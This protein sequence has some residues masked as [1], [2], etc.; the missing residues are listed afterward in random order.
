MVKANF[1]KSLLEQADIPLGA[2]TA[3]SGVAHENNI[4]SVYLTV[5]EENLESGENIAAIGEIQDTG[6][7]QLDAL[8][9]TTIL[10]VNAMLTANEKQELE[11]ALG[12][13]E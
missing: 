9:T 8:Y 11:S 12:I 7:I 4:L 6:E 1:I 10:P 13:G 3:I 5:G 2:V